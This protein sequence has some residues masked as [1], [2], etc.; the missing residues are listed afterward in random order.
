MK[1]SLF[2]LGAA[3]VV[4]LSSCTKNEVLE[5]AENR[6]IG[7]DAFVGKN[8]RAIID[9]ENPLTTFK[10]F[11]SFSDD[12][13]YNGVFNNVTVSNPTGEWKS[14]KTEYWQKDKSYIFQ[15]YSG[16]ATATPTKNG[17]EFTEYT[18]TSGDEDLLSAAIVNKGP[19]TDVNNAG[20]VDLT[21][22]HVLSQIKFTFTNGFNGNVKL[23]ISN[24][25]VNNLATEGNYTLSAV[26]T[27]TWTVSEENSVYTPAIS[28]TAFG[29]G[30]TAVTDSKIVL[31]QNVK[32]KTVTFDL[33]VSGSLDFKSQTIT[34]KLPDYPM[35]EGNVYNF[36]TELNAE[37]IKDPGNPGQTLKPI[38]FTAS[39]SEWSPEQSD[40][41]G[42]VQ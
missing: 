31:P 6:A 15:A 20:T 27:G 23:A 41:S 36:T 29:A 38:E 22:R 13:L 24:V 18:A 7:F 39:V 14:K 11:G 3:A 35:A 32:D 34:V 12:T 4:A 30:E 1:N 42:S 9:D 40:G 8:T 17:V 26:N 2:L 25:K 19:I 33:V 5:V 21:F 16:T 10:V 37:N 28:G